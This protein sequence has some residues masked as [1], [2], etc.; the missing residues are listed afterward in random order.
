MTGLAYG[1]ANRRPA[2]RH[3]RFADSGLPERVCHRW[4]SQSE[5]LAS[6][7]TGDGEA[8]QVEHVVNGSMAEALQIVLGIHLQ[9]GVDCLHREGGRHSDWQQR[10]DVA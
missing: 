9:G 5:P 4:S 10:I 2:R 8:A 1:D 6:K 3:A 7:H